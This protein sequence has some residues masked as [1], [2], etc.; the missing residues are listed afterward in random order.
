[1]RLRG[2]EVR[3]VQSGK[4]TALIVP[5][6]ARVAFEAGR[7]YPVFTLGAR[8]DDDGEKPKPDARIIVTHVEATELH[9]VDYRTMQKAGFKY[10]EDLHEYWSERH[11]DPGPPDAPKAVP[12]LVVRFQLDRAAER[13]YL[14]PGPRGGYVEVA[15]DELPRGVMKDE[16]ECVPESWQNNVSLTARRRDLEEAQRRREAP[17]T[18]PLPERLALAM[19][20]AEQGGV[21]ISR[22][23]GII[24]KRLEAIERILLDAA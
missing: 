9:E 15:D 23:L 12:V 4:R 7:S 22:Q 2:D 24:G 1:M 5:Y 18:T 17:K 16:G 14:R 20:Q 21:D 19:R 11:A 13:R 10:R 3:Q 8:E 6:R